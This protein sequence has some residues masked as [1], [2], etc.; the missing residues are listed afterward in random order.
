[1]RLIGTTTHQ[2]RDS[3]DTFRRGSSLGSV[4]HDHQLLFQKR[5]VIESSNAPTPADGTRS[6]RT[7][8]PILGTMGTGSGPL[9]GLNANHAKSKVTSLIRRKASE[10]LDEEDER[11]L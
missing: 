2:E 9:V 1:M 8:Q 10:G 4:M 6:E 5:S 11:D 3:D 7:Q